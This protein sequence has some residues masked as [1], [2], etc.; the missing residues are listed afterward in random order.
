VHGHSGE[1]NL[2]MHEAR[3]AHETALRD[4]QWSV[5]LWRLIGVYDAAGYA[6]A[7][8]P[9]YNRK[10]QFVKCR[11]LLPA[12]SLCVLRVSGWP[13]LR[14]TGWTD[15]ACRCEETI[16]SRKCGLLNIQPCTQRGVMP[17]AAQAQRHSI[18]DM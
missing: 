10:K 14:G 2:L 16:Q 12:K 13:A 17:E 6:T 18:R 3:G 11:A 1:S 8:S 7:G 15:S 4:E 5:L 9:I